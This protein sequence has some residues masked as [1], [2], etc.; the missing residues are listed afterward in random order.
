MAKGKRIYTGEEV[1]VK[2][3]S[4]DEEIAIVVNKRSFAE[5]YDWT[6]DPQALDILP[7]YIIQQM[8]D[9]SGGGGSSALK[10]TLTTDINGDIDLSGQTGMPVSG[11]LA[12]AKTAYIGDTDYS[13]SLTYNPTTQVLSTGFS[14]A[15][16]L[17][18]T[19][20]F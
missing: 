3:Y 2:V 14:V 4:T 17:D 16:L 6:S 12:T 7:R 20:T 5:A 15:T 13:Q 11:T 8:I 19:I 9:D 1:K 10:F 18:I